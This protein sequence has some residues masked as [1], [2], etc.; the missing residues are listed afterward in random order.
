[1]K[2]TNPKA[3]KSCKNQTLKDP[4]A[5]AE[6]LLLWIAFGVLPP[7]LCFL[8]G[9][10]GSVFHVTEENVIWYALGGLMLGL[11][12]DALFLRRI[13]RSAYRLPWCVPIFM[14]LFYSVGMFGF[15]MGVP[16]FNV[17]LGALAGFYSGRRAHHFGLAADETGRMAQLTALF[18]AGVLGLACVAA[19]TLAACSPSTPADIAGLLGLGFKPA[20]D[21]IL[22]VAAALGAGLVLVEYWL[23]KKVFEVAA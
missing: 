21:M 6:A 19:M 3:L 15:F 18:A 2:K 5:W 13:V 1:M 7:L 14:Y 20:M 17:L 16:L 4:L 22:G 10:W 12:L 11:A 8:A 9:W 23:T